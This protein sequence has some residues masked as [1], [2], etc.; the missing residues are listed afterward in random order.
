MADKY[1]SLGEAIQAFLDTHGIKDQTSV[2]TVINEW[3]QIMGKPIAQN[4]EKM[5][6]NRNTLYI[7]MKS[8]VWRNELQM[9]RLKIKKIVNEKMKK[10]L[11]KEVKIM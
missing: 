6:F 5:W 7:K 10:E 4:T 8:P 1:M 9:A 3:E 2:Q 11:I